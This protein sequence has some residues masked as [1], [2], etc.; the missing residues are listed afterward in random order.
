MQEQLP[1][2]KYFWIEPS[3]AQV[4]ARLIAKQDD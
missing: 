2:A 3:K 4:D 1:D